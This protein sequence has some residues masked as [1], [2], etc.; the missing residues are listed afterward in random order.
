MT[1]AQTLETATLFNGVASVDGSES[2][3]ELRLR[4]AKELGLDEP[5]PSATL[6]RAL[7]DEDFAHRLLVSRNAPGF[8]RPLIDDPDNLKYA[9]PSESLRA[10]VY[11]SR[12][13]PARRSN[14]ELAKN[15]AA[16]LLRWGKSGF[17]QVSP[18]VYATRT[19]A[20]NACPHLTEAPNQLAYKVKLAR[21]EDM[22]VCNLCGCV[23]ARKARLP[24]ERCPGAHPSEAGMNRWG[25]PLNAQRG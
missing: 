12:P 13:E 22:R 17:T 14:A 11:A 16:A 4:F 2:W 18:E 20:C 1:P 15:A 3:D 8:L 23:A 10:E 25:E 5:V 21:E 19:A 9:D 6:R 24:D 7:N